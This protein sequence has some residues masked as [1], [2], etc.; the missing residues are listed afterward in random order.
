M[1]VQLKDQEIRRLESELQQQRIQVSSHQ[2]SEFI[3]K[4]NFISND[5]LPR[6]GAS[7]KT[8]SSSNIQTKQPTSWLNQLLG[9]VFSSANAWS[10]ATKIIQV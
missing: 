10:N 7:A 9:V 2:D 5:T 3:Q 1:E 6:H 4:S 8:T